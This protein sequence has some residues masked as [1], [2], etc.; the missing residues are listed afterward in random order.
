M[1]SDN[2]F[3]DNYWLLIVGTTA[4]NQF[5]PPALDIFRYVEKKGMEMQLGIKRNNDQASFMLAALREIRSD[6]K[7]GKIDEEGE[8]DEDTRP[9][10]GPLMGPAVKDDGGD[11]KP[12]ADFSLPDVLE[13]IGL[14]TDLVRIDPHV[15]SM[16]S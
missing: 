13:F 3:V 1:V 9:I 10:I 6:D 11:A 4:L 14:E 5:L 15:F 7:K 2:I 16:Q 12:P 8:E